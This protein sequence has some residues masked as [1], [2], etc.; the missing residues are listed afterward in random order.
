MMEDKELPTEYVSIR[1]AWIKAINR[2]AEAIA[3][4]YR[5]DVLQTGQ[6]LDTQTGYNTVIESIIA[7]H[8]L[9]VDYGE[10][11]ILSEVNDWYDTN[12]GEKLKNKDNRDRMLFYQDLFRFMIKTLNKYGMLFETQPKGYSNVNMESIL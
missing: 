11:P 12:K 10:A 3:Y 6:F 5:N 1:N 2:V 4:R 9:M 7:L 8:C